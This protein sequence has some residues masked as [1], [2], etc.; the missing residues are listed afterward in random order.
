MVGVAIVGSVYVVQISKSVR[1]TA[2][3]VE[4]ISEILRDSVLRPLSNIPVMMESAGN[5]LGWVQQY[6]SKDRRNE[7]DE[8]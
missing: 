7:D 3:N 1:R 2:R 6:I 5:V 4:D 8:R